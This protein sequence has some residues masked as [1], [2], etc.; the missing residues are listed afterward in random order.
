MLALPEDIFWLS[1]FILFS[2]AVLIQ[3]L[4]YFIF[5]IRLSPVQTPLKRGK[6]PPVS[7]II[8]AR[9][10]AD[11]LET[12]LPDFLSQDYPDFELIV[13]NDCSE[14]ESEDILKVFEKQSE[15]LKVVT[16]HK[17]AS[18][19]HS[20]KMALFVGIKSAKNEIL[21]LSD[22]D[23]Q[24]VS[25]NWISNMVSGFGKE[26]AFVL[27]YGG[28]L[29]EKGFL[30]KYIRFDSFFIAMQYLGMAKAGLPY[31]GVGRNLS[32]RKSVFF[33]NKGFGTHINLQS[34]DDDLF[35]NR[36][37]RGN[38]T[39]VISNYDS[40]TRSVPASRFSEFT[41]QKSRHMST[42]S[43]YRPIS[44]F[45]LVLEP[46]TRIMFYA[47]GILLIILTSAWQIPLILFGTGIITK[48]IVFYRVQKSLNEPDLLLFSLMFD[49]ISPFI[50][51]YFLRV[52]RRNQNRSYE[53]K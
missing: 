32:Y 52:S 53:W 27:G 1:I 8:C 21:L 50:N 3:L 42:A 29:K 41:K 25:P 23:C 17:E 14:D 5:Y 18:L 30:N 24:T 38:N 45:L 44:K 47:L 43:L 13:V 33:D 22:A 7:I 19:S 46:V 10:E 37:A 20:K 51:T 49:A 16:I 11:N 9:N 39:S 28:Y 48:L 36:I 4:Y 35:I 12:F 40:I 34:G 15:K 2:F 31:M 6:K 26:T